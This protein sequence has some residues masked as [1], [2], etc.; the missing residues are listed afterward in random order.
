MNKTI[1]AFLTAALAVAGAT[2]QEAAAAGEAGEG[3]ARES[4]RPRRSPE[5]IAAEREEEMRET[6]GRI[7]Y[8]PA[9]PIFLVADAREQSSDAAPARV[10]EVVRN[11]FKMAATNEAVV[12]GAG[13]TPQK[14]AVGF[15]KQ[16]KALLAVV[17]Y[18]GGKGEPA[19]AVFPEERVALVNSDAAAAFADGAEAELRIV[20]ECWRGIGFITGAG[21]FQNSGS[22]MQP[23]GSPLELDVVEWQVISP[24]QFQQMSKFLKKY[25]ARRG[26]RVTYRDAV[27]DG[28]APAPTN[29]YQ[30]AIWDAAHNQTNATEKA[31]NKAA[32]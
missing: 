8:I 18:E 15:R 23:V 32:K 7:D 25:G 28:W 9:G 4:R 17:V 6:G 21:Y 26:R 11:M 16:R 3:A 19:L 22:V 1:V 29:D 31:A 27:Q 13:E 20:K 14:A 24:M 12:I 2:A 30:R 10:A 5:E